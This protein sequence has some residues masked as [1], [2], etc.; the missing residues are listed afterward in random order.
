MASNMVA[1]FFTAGKVAS[2]Q[3]KSSSDVK[4]ERK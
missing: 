1:N 4:V 3:V 2:T